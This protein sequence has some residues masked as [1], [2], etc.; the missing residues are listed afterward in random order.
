MSPE[1]VIK[2][3]EPIISEVYQIINSNNNN[4]KVDVEN[5]NSNK[6]YE[7][8][9]CKKYFELLFGMRANNSKSIDYLEKEG[10]YFQ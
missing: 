2:S 7:I 1:E 6:T 4:T 9:V 8:D 3:K 10:M 5:G